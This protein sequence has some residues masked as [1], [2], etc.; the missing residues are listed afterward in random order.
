[1]AS[2]LTLPMG[3]KLVDYDERQKPSTGTLG[4]LSLGVLSLGVLSSG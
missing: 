2:L 4:E 3:M 1:L